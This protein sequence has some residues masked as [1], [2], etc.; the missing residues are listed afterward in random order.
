MSEDLQVLSVQSNSL[1]RAQSVDCGG[2]LRDY[3]YLVL[4]SGLAEL[5]ATM[6]LLPSEG[7]TVIDTKRLRLFQPESGYFGR[8]NLGIKSGF[9]GPKTN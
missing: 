4:L 6:G 8:H 7:R 1:A 5:L 9:R 2:P 3:L